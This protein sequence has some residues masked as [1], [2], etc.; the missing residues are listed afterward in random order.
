[1]NLTEKNRSLLGMNRLIRTILKKI[2]I[3]FL[4]N[5]TDIINRI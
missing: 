5:F 1:M 2:M 4:S 3:L